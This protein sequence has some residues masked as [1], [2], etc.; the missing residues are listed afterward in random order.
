MLAWRIAKRQ[1]A[2]D[3]TGIGARSYGGRWNSP[4]IAVIYAG[5]T[6]E[7]SA[8][9]KLVHAGDILPVDLVLV[10]LELPEDE[11]LYYRFSLANLP[12]GWDDLPGSTAASELGN[13]FINSGTHLGMIVP[14]VVMPEASNII[15]NPNH[16]AFA[17]VTMTIIRTFEFDSR[18]R[19]D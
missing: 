3:R 11:T 7:I 9:E 1:F 17:N 14:S 19:T 8:L 16:T 12:S 15:I 5:M 6:P 13:A 4:G 10:S 18:L 2:L